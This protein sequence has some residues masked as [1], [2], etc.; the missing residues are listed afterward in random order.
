M[1][2]IVENY[3]CMQFQGKLMNQ[4]VE[5]GKKPIFGSDFGPFAQN[6]GRQTFFFKNLAPPVTRYHGQLSSCTI[7]GK[8]NHSILQKLSDGRTDRRTDRQADESDFIGP[9][10]TNI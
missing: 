1:L 9:C 3:H 5:N 4:T 6:S 7:S 10:P 8:T 2:D